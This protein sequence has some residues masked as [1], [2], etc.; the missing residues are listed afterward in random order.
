MEAALSFPPAMAVKQDKW[1]L[2]ERFGQ[3]LFLA[4]VKDFA[5]ESFER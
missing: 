5:N 1:K 2:L 4:P 3:R